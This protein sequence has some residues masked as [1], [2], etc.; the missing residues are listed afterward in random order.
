[1]RL[2]VACANLG[3]LESRNKIKEAIKNGLI[4]VNNKV[5]TKTSLNVELGDEISIKDTKHF[6]S[7][8]ANKLDLFLDSCDIDVRDLVVLDIGS[9]TGGFSQVLLQRGVRLIHCVDVGS[10][11]LHKS[12]KEDTRVVCYENTDIREF[13]AS[14]KSYSMIVCD[15]SFI[16]VFQILHKIEELLDGIFILLFKPQF[17]VG[18]DVRRNKKGVVLDREK[19]MLSLEN[20]RE[21][22]Q[23]R[24]FEM[25][26]IEESKLKGKEGNEEFFIA[27]RRY[28]VS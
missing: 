8:A 3:L 13:E 11:Q 25:L 5:C 1:M 23:N 7:R 17:E 4:L 14:I 9:S 2:D 28:K 26:K 10:N 21:T 15:V 20:I 22:L 16:S 12:I 19:I 6:V 27:T 24:G 18:K